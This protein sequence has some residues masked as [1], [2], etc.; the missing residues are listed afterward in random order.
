M[1][2][3][4][5]MGVGWEGM[6]R[7]AEWWSCEE[8]GPMVYNVPWFIILGEVLVMM[9]LPYL[10]VQ[11]GKKNFGYAVPFGV[12]LGLVIWLSYYLAYSVLN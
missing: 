2:M 9:S 4:L 3:G 11:L 10:L 5:G 12:V 1:L 8:S 6:A 7:G